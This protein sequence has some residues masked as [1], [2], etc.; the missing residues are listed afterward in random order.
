MKS[1]TEQSL[2]ALRK[3]GHR[4]QVVEHFN[5]FTKRRHDLFGFI[6]IIALSPGNR[7]IGVQ[8]TSGS[9]AAARCTKIV[10][11]CK[12]AAADFMRCGGFLEVHGWRKVGAKGKRKLWD[13]R[14]LQ[15]QLL[16]DGAII[17]NEV[18]A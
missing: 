9:N 13:C 12:D 1:P 4:A 6:D 18:P 15:A 8:T 17:F 3:S 5:S 7:I 16:V 10:D 2:K 11:E 14:V